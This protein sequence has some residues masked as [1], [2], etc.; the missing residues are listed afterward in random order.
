MRQKKRSRARNKTSSEAKETKGSKEPTELYCNRTRKMNLI[1]RLNYNK[2]VE[3]ALPYFSQLLDLIGVEK[4]EQNG[5]GISAR[6][7]PQPF[8]QIKA[9]PLP[10]KESSH[11]LDPLPWGVRSQRLYAP[12]QR[13][14]PRTDY[15]TAIPCTARSGDSK[16]SRTN[17]R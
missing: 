3:W 17:A 15:Q 2:Q 7:S 6:V 5:K 4:P 16:G 8:P 14:I 11:G 9:K 1:W 10:G 13:L 12:S